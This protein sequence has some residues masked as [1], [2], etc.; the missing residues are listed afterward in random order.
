MSGELQFTHGAHTAEVPQPLA[1]GLERGFARLVLADVSREH[2]RFVGV[3]DVLSP[4]QI[5]NDGFLYDDPML[6]TVP[7]EQLGDRLNRLAI[8]FHAQLEPGRLW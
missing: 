8:Y 3:G 1:H 4:A 6:V 7:G 2:H 5:V